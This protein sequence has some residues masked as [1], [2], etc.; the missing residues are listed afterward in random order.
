M[1]RHDEALRLA[2]VAVRPVDPRPV[3]PRVVAT[4]RAYDAVAG[5][6]ARLLPDLALETPLDRAVL[7]GFAEMLREQG[8]LPVVEVGCGTGRVTRHLH[9]AG[10]A[11]TGLDLSPQMVSRARATCPGVPFA[12]AQASALPLRDGSVGGL[13]AWYSLIHLPTDA[14]GDVFAEFARVVLPGGTLLVAFQAGRGQRVDRTT[15]YEQPVALSY[16]RHDVDAVTTALEVAGFTL[17]AT[18]RRAAARS[19][20]STPQAALLARRS[21]SP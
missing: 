17:Y 9:D 3:D 13:L 5:D 14:L 1:P 6:Y 2:C 16:Y 19:F 15:S 8:D 21:P 12:V 11:V 4:R 7:A 18:V 20:E 10:L